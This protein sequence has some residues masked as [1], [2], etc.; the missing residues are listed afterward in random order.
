MLPCSIHL[1]QYQYNIPFIIYHII[2]ISHYPITYSA[3]HN[4][5]AH[6]HHIVYIAFLITTLH[7]IIRCCI[8]IKTVIRTNKQTNKQKI[9]AHP[10]NPYIV[11][12]NI[13]H[14]QTAMTSLASFWFVQQL[15]CRRQKGFQ[16]PVA[17]ADRHGI[18]FTRLHQ[19]KFTY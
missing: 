4:I 15:N 1:S 16:V 19:N 2:T 14:I 12:H 11:Q 6:F 10:H 7:I 5:T 9:L 3:H 18:A 13:Q 17:L 8:T